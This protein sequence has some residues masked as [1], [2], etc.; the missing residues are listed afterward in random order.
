MRVVDVC[1]HFHPPGYVDA[2]R[3]GESAIT[4]KGDAAGNPE[5]H[6]D[7]PLRAA[8][9]S[10]GMFPR[11]HPTNQIGTIRSM[12]DAAGGKATTRLGLA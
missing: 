7:W 1:N 10:L 4:V 12:L 6:C 8:A 2:L 3:A 5:V 11:I 9:E